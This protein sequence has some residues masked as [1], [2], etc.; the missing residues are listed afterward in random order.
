[1]QKLNG[2]RQRDG[3]GVA[4]PA[5]VNPFP[6]LVRFEASIRTKHSEVE[7][8]DEVWMPA[9]IQRRTSGRPAFLLLSIPCLA[10]AHD[11][12]FA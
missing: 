9:S 5:G 2:G 4:P 6:C 8:C 12:A 3:F 1:M 7:Q 11:D 10:R